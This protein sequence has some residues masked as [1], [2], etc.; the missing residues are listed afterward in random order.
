MMMMM[1]MVNWWWWIDGNAY[2]SW[3]LIPLCYN[4]GLFMRLVGLYPQNK[5]R[6]IKPQ[7]GLHR[8]EQKYLNWGLW[9]ILWMVAKSCASRLVVYRI[10]IVRV[11]NHVQC[12]CPRRYELV[13][14]TLSFT[15][16]IPTINLSEIVVM[17]TNWTLSF[18]GAPYCRIL[19]HSMSKVKWVSAAVVSWLVV[20]PTVGGF[21]IH[22]KN[23]AVMFLGQ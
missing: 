5:L 14:I 22:G 10:K 20:H 3:W 1:M 17:F 11:S 18:T 15:I 13:N 6:W 8:S 21:C 2:P 23:S 16:V 9:Y 7:V 12:G 19:S 4:R